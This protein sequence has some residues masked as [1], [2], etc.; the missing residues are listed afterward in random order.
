MRIEQRIAGAMLQPTFLMADVEVVAT[1]EQH[2]P[3][4]AGKADSPGF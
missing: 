4:E 3:H 1:Y 2:Q